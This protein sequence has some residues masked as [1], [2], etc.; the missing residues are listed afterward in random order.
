[1]GSQNHSILQA[2]LAGLLLSDERYTVATKLSLDVQNMSISDWFKE[3]K[4]ELKPDICL[5]STDSDFDFI[6]TRVE[7]DI[8]RRTEMPV[9]A[10]EIL[11]PT[12]KIAVIVAKIRAYLKIGVKS[13]W[14]V[15]PD[16]KT[17]TV[18]S[19]D[20][21]TFGMQSVEVVDNNLDI[22]LPM[23]KIFATRKN[24]RKSVMDN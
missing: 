1:M 6:D 11:S 14:L 21:N 19:S 18:Y 16:L 7:D 12:D 17:I 23:Q 9:L 3:A 8:L 15:A 4:N 2:R 10:V 20:T 22:R 5:Y 13:C 24:P